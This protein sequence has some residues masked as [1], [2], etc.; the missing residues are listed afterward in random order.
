MVMEPYKNE[1]ERDLQ[2]LGTRQSTEKLGRHV[3]S[4]LKHWV[5]LTGK[6]LGNWEDKRVTARWS[7]G[8]SKNKDKNCSPKLVLLLILYG[9]W[10]QNV[11]VSK[12]AMILLFLLIKSM[13]W[14][15]CRY[16]LSNLF[17]LLKCHHCCVLVLCKLVYSKGERTWYLSD[18]L[19]IRRSKAKEREHNTCQMFSLSGD[20]KSIILSQK[21]KCPQTAPI[22][23][24]GL[25]SPFSA[26]KIMCTADSDFN[27]LPKIEW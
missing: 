25:H 6:D 9:W 11:P 8:Y 20:Q 18:V 22:S 15:L 10:K 7:V 24:I 27:F 1:I 13:F 5:T 3:V 16:G 26:P 4:A 21:I 17:D 2:A 19:P 12:T 14:R 23:R